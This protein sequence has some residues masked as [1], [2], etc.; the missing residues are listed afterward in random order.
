MTDIERAIKKLEI[1]ADCMR[2]AASALHQLGGEGIGHACELDGA[3]LVMRGWIEELKN[4]ES[5]SPPWHE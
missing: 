1:A 2:M 3:V 5:G 4:Q